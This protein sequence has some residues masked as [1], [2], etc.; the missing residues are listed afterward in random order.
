MSKT[1]QFAY[2]I[3]IALALGAFALPVTAQ[4]GQE[5]DPPGQETAQ[6]APQPA[7]PDPPS[8]SPQ[9]VPASAD[10]TAPPDRASIRKRFEEA[11]VSLEA[12]DADIKSVL[13]DLSKQADIPIVVSSKVSGTVTLR[14]KN[15]L[16]K[17]VFKTVLK[18]TQCAYETKNG[19]YIVKPRPD[20]TI[21]MVR[22]KPPVSRPTVTVYREPSLAVPVYPVLPPPD[23]YYYDS[24]VWM[25]GRWVPRSNFYRGGVRFGPFSSAY[26]IL[27]SAPTIPFA[28][29]T[30]SVEQVV[31]PRKKK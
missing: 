31:I 4:E 17:D 21:T 2:A 26:R 28:D 20:V 12:E 30:V 11:R 29:A 5:T 13:I 3:G 27:P 14:L 15:M 10:D 6:P 1:R 19:L 22:R 16:F 18:I 8:D 7:N 23:F 24:R 9:A 25:N